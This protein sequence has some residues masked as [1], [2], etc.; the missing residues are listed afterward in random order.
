MAKKTTKFVLLSSALT[1]AA[2]ITAWVLRKAQKGGNVY[3]VEIPTQNKK[4]KPI[5]KAAVTEFITKLGCE[6]NF[7]IAGGKPKETKDGKLIYFL[8]SSDAIPL[9]DLAEQLKSEFN[10]PSC[11]CKWER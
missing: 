8:L 11:T 7:A 2:G 1:V 4:G 5:C 10:L 6:S 3:R 9:N